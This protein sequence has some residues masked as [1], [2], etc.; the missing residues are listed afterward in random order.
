MA[1]LYQQSLGT[2]TE[3]NAFFNAT[4][5]VGAGKISTTRGKSKFRV[6]SN[7]LGSQAPGYIKLQMANRLHAEGT[8][9]QRGEACKKIFFEDTAAGFPSTATT[10]G[11][12]ED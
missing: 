9:F 3:H 5:L 1:N 2:S 12:V 6:W 7:C 8:C 11:G 10:R 4:T